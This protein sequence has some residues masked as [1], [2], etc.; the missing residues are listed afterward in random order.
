VPEISPALEAV[1]LRALQK[2]PAKRYSTADEM[3]ADL[4]AA[5][6]GQISE[7]TATITRV[8]PAAGGA[9]GAGATTTIQAAP[10][11]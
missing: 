1:I 6:R 7:D 8:L 5:R 2:D 9:G 10:L 11:A 3:L 4:D